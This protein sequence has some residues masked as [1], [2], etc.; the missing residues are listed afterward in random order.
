VAFTTDTYTVKPIVFPGGDIGKL[1]VCGTVND[2]AVK[3]ARPIAVAA[4][5]IIEEGFPIDDLK[6][7]ARSMR[8]AADDVG[9]RVVAGDTKVVRRGEADGLFIAASGIGSILPGMNISVSLARPG[10]AILISGTIAD[11][12][13]AILNARESLG[14]MPEIRSDVA[15]VFD[16]VERL[17]AV[18][19]RLHVMRDPTR[20][21]LAGILHEIA[22]ASRITILLREGS[23]PV[24]A[25]VRACCGILGMDPL[26]VACE[27]RVA[28]IVERVAAGEALRLMRGA[29]SGGDA[30]LIGE[31]AG[32]PYIE[33]VPAVR[34]ETNIGSM[35]FVPPLDGELLSRI[36]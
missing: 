15:P 23:I 36:C 14:F 2:L 9:V 24:R 11:H 35:R 17:S 30:A 18:A 28:V 26:H 31:V 5:F 12:G 20:G 6:A 1:A 25:D 21:G 3:G 34:L 7:V 27:G 29:E 13:M 19:E 32:D 4:G 8:D 16:I 22:K 33:G 10:D